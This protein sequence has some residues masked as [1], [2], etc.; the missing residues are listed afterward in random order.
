MSMQCAQNVLLF[1]VLA[2]ISARFRILRSYRD[3]YYTSRPFLC[4]LGHMYIIIICPL[5][6]S[7]NKLIHYFDSASWLH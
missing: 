6:N 5:N 7:I 2:V 3:T 1:S 4:A